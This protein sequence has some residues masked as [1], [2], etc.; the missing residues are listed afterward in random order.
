M[1]PEGGKGNTI[2][3]EFIFI[4]ALLYFILMSKI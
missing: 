3:F 4:I 1:A 2:G